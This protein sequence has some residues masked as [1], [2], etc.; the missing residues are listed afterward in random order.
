[1]ANDYAELVL[2]G[3]IELTE[4]E[5]CLENLDLES[6]REEFSLIKSNLNIIKAVDKLIVK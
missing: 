5:E 4:N 3:K 2:S 6:C 1:M